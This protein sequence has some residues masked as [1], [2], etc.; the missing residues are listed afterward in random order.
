MKFLQS[1]LITLAEI[2]IVLLAS[3]SIW[4][5]LRALFQERKEWRSWYRWRIKK[6]TTRAEKIFKKLFPDTFNPI[7]LSRSSPER[8]AALTEFH[9]QYGEIPFL[10]MAEVLKVV[11]PEVWEEFVDLG[12]GTG[13]AVF[14]AALLWPMK[15]Y[16]GVELLSALY[17]TSLEKKHE[18]THLLS[19]V[20]YLKSRMEKI[21][22]LHEDIQQFDFH[23]ADIIFV[24]LPNWPEKPWLSLVE[25]FHHLKIG[26]RVI[27]V[28]KTIHSPIFERIYFQFYSSGKHHYRVEVFLKK[29]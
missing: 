19:K 1:D 20:S 13:R 27:C 9:L 14:T 2:V 3:Y 4:G 18:L 10:V 24:C 6:S 7:Q 23:K 11:K 29:Y 17:H 26:S 16:Q 22:F 15:S 25:K 28:D 12:S 21:I 5:I 8:L